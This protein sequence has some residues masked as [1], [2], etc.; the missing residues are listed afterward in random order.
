MIFEFN[1]LGILILFILLVLYFTKENKDK[2]P[3]KL[4]LLTTYIT[5]LFYILTFIGIESNNYNLSGRL[6]FLSLVILFTLFTM[7]NAVYILNTKYKNKLSILE[8][9]L[10]LVKVLTIIISMIF[11]ILILTSKMYLLDDRL[12]FGNNILN[13]ILSITIILDVLMLIWGKVGKLYPVIIIKLMMLFI[14]LWY[15]N[16]SVISEGVILITLY[17]Y[18]IFENYHVKELE[19]TKLERDYAYRNMIDK[20]AFLKNLSHEIRTPINTIDGFSQV[21][22]DS[23]ELDGIKEDIKD[24]R[25]ASHELIDIINNMIDLSIIESGNLEIIND[26]Y[27]IYDMFDNIKNITKSKMKGKL[28]KFEFQIE[29]NIPEIL[30][31]DQERISQVILNLLGNSIKFTK[32][33]TINLEV[34]CVRN[35]AIARLIIKVIDTGEGMKREQLNTLFERKNDGSIGLVLANHLIEL[36][37]G[38]IDVDSV[39][40]E[41]TTFVV[42][43]DQKIIA[44]KEEKKSNDV[45]AFKAVGKRILVVDDNKLNLKVIV[46]MLAAY[47]VEVIE[48]SSGNECL[49]ILDNDTDFDLIFMDDMMPK[50]SGTETLSIIKKVSRIDGYYIPIVVLTANAMTGIREKYL[51]VG[52]DDYLAKPIDKQELARILKKYLK[53]RK[54][55]NSE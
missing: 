49:D 23:N 50:L 21:I 47:G 22:Q 37:N 51:G 14:S 34:S 40:G 1:L 11:S 41:G 29:D 20:Y 32:K 3:F 27:N 35:S 38:K 8:K 16:I 46:K 7:Y 12:V 5:E 4:I 28:V 52:F 54:S 26:N 45:K 43:I 17:I 6:Y 18:L 48:A 42:S 36:M 9:K 31:G 44:N 30:L 2:F 10:N 19:T 39:Y 15:P 55:K 53:G 24:I 25:T 13:I 33:G